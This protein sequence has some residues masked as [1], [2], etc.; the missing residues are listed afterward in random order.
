MQPFF[1]Q[2]K[3]PEKKY[4]I[5][6]IILLTSIIASSILVVSFVFY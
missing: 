2:V 5:L 6:A 3:Y 4:F 1:H